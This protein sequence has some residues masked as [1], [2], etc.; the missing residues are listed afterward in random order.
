MQSSSAA[1][2]G[3]V[4]AISSQDYQSSLGLGP[5]QIGN[6]SGA[7]GVQI[8]SKSQNNTAGNWM[9]ES[10]NNAQ[11]KK[12]PGKGMQLGKPKK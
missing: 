4:K 10:S 8:T 1:S 11:T 6:A 9:E 7:G 2:G 12:A 5:A 3:A